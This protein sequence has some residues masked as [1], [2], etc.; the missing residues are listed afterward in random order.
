[1]LLTR[2]GGR[3]LAD[4]DRLI[5]KAVAGDESSLESLLMH[6]YNPLLQWISTALMRGDAGGVVADDVLQETMVAAF[7]SV[8]QIEPRGSRA[9]FSWLKT[10]ARTRLINLIDARRAQKRGGQ[11]ANAVATSILN[12]IAAR[13]PSPSLIARRKEA[14][15]AIAKAMAQ[16]EPGR[17]KVLQLRYGQGLSIQEVATRIGKSEGAVKML[18]SRSI[19]QLRESIA[20][21]EGFTRDA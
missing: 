12:R 2:K 8:R 19:E 14:T 1:V 3:Q 11:L 4:L 17:R 16:L 15:E 18:I 5:E 20:N 13:D 9:F 10:I 21:I 6:F 7:R